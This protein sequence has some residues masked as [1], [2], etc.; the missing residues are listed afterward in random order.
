VDEEAM[1]RAGLQSQRNKT[2][3]KSCMKEIISLP[4]IIIIIIIIIPFSHHDA[5]RD[6][7]LS[8]L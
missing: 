5:Q 2:N 4:I 8:A 3:N 7:I 1:A 6:N